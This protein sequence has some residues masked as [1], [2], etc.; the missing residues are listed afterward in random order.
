MCMYAINFSHKD[1][2][3]EIVSGQV[4]QDMHS[5][6]FHTSVSPAIDTKFTVEKKFKG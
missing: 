6:H 3:P 2:S 4:V 5:S 1:W